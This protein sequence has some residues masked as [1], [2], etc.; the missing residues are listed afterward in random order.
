VTFAE[1]MLLAWLPLGLLLFAFGIWA[2]GRARRRRDTLLGA[3]AARLAPRFRARRRLVRD[4]LLAGAASLCVLALAGPQVGTWMRAVQEHGVDVM[5]VLDTSRS[6]LAADITPS[7]LERARREVRGL[8]GRMHGDRIGLVSFAGDARLICPLTA[9]P[10]SF[11]LFLDDV[12]TRTNATGGTAV[13]EGLDLAVESFDPDVTTARVVLLLTDGEDHDSD[14]PATEIAYKARARGIPVHVVAFGTADGGVIPV[15][16]AR[17]RQD[18][19]RDASGQPVISRPDEELLERIAS[20]G[21][22]AYL[23]AA[24]TAFPLDELWDKRIS[25]MQ[26][27]TRSTAGRREGINRFQWALVAALLLLGTRAILPDGRTA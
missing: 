18:V 22:G 12:D 13:A 15:S 21:E 20:I 14:P 1:P 16:D 3:Q 4:A 10:A 19:V 2:A 23:S 26:G 11:R 25:Q 7:R 5:V 27:V 6:M 17:G 8:L 24:R 9:D